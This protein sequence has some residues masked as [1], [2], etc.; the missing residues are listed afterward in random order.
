MTL[1]RFAGWIVILSGA[2]IPRFASSSY[3]TRNV[4]QPPR[5]CMRRRRNESS[6]AR[7]A[8]RRDS[9]V[10]RPKRTTE[11]TTNYKLLTT[12]Y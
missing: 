1:H 3:D 12:D 9:N 2:K 8:E 10:N 4:A 6:A 5:L 7:R 11:P